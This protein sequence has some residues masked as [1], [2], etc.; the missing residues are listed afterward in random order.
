[1]PITELHQVTQWPLCW[2]PAKPRTAKRLGRTQFKATRA[3]AEREI[4]EEME[5]W[6][7]QGYMLSAAPPY[8]KGAVDPGVALWWN[9]PRPDKKPSELR[10][11]ACDTWPW[12]ED[13][14]H[15]IALTL[16]GLRSF[17]RY[18]TYT[19]EQAAEGARPALPPPAEERIDW[20]G[21]LGVGRDW[22]LA[23]VEAIWK[24]KAEKAHP[25]RGGSAEAMASLNAAMDAARRDLGDG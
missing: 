24:T 14:M 7:A 1:M 12:I 18:G 6:R 22:P 19:R 4:R 21:I 15:A 5:R 20:P 11:L 8:M 17:E 25:D 13:N 16:H 2:P 10:V 23:A 9:M 3:K